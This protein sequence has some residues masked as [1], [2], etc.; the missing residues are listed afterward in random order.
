[1]VC[2]EMESLISCLLCFIFLIFEVN[3]KGF[4]LSNNRLRGQS[5]RDELA[6]KIENVDSL[7]HS[8]HNSQHFFLLFSYFS[9][10]DF[11][12][13]LSI[14]ESNSRSLGDGGRSFNL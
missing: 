4:A 14:N 5:Y 8:Q 12:T 9:S 6:H 2:G 10:F 13:I 3:K 7:H 11:S 1:M